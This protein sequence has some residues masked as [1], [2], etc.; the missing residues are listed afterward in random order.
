MAIEFFRKG[1]KGYIPKA[2]V[3][4]HGQIGFNHGAVEKFQIKNGQ[5]VLLG[6][7]KDKRIV[8]IRRIDEAEEGAKRV[9]V[10]G[11]SGSI[12]AKAFFDYFGITPK[13]TKSYPLQVEPEGKLLVF[14]LESETDRKDD[15]ETKVET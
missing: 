11:N 7:D 10:K 9:I 12:G 8:A 2:S 14:H 3:R 13:K 1:G 15:T 4:M 5:Y 6:Y